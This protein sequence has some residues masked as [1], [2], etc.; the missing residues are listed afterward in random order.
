MKYWFVTKEIGGRK[1][2]GILNSFMRES[3]S[4]EERPEEQGR[5]TGE[6]LL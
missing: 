3:L 1:G 2:A 5:E 4:L 6:S